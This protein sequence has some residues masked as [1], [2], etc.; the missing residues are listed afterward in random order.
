MNDL[1]HIVRDMMAAQ[2]IKA[3]PV[4]QEPVKKPPTTP[5]VVPSVIT[6][7]KRIHRLHAK[8]M[9]LKQVSEKLGM[10]FNTLRGIYSKYR[11]HM[12]M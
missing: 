4:R 3:M 7:G 6:H 11:K 12:G 2:P 5:S 8:G 9:P 10:N 1:S